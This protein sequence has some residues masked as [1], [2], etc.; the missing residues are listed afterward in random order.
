VAQTPPVP[1]DAFVARVS[2]PTNKTGTAVNVA[3]GYFSYLGGANNE[4][5]NAITVDSASGAVITGWT[6]SPNTAADGTFPVFPN[7]NS[8]QGTLNGPQDAFVA[9][10]NTAASVGQTTIASW[11]NYFGGTGTESGTGIAL[12]VNQN[13]YLAG[14]TNSVDLQ[15][16]KP[17][18]PGTTNSGGYDAF[19]AQLGTAVSLSIQGSLTL[20]ANQAFIPAGNQ[21]TFTYIITNNGPDL[22]SGITVQD[23]LSS[24]VTGVPVT[25][26][27]ASTS[28][29]SC[30]GVSTGSV[31]S[32]SLTQLQSGSTATVTIVVTPT[33]S[34]SGSQATF[35]GGTVQ[36]LGQGN[37]VFA[38]TSVPATMSDFGMQVSPI[39]QS[40]PVAGDVATYTVV[41][42]PHPLFTPSVNLSCSGQPSNSSCTFNP[43]SVA[44][45]GASGSSATMTVS[46]TPRPIT[47]T[48]SNSTRL[49]YSV[50]LLLPGLVFTFGGTRRRKVAGMLMLCAL[51]SMLIL[52]PACS[53]S[54]TQT[55][56]AGTP[57][58]SYT[59]TV[60]ATSGSDSK[61]QTVSLTV[62]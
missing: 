54:T 35:N 17:L 59:I 40:I 11:A 58:G 52:V 55:P 16:N 45:Q 57:A 36:V 61:S 5:G 1:T 34:S 37:I 27:S 26:V 51:L 4:A 46:T 24:S 29:G 44:M 49:F 60:T 18:V 42:T 3:L 43:T 28:S 14:D 48:A 39:N 19:V 2:N 12:D 25:F 8:I 56:A 30:G 32:C 10:L 41:L 22:A 15:V 50:A 31:V 21:A 13:T 53:H 23:N 9:R 33:G 62:P 38:Q 6:Q 20:G 7:P 47:T